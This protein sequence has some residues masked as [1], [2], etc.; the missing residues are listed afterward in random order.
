MDLNRWRTV[1]VPIDLYKVLKDMADQ[2]DR[3]VSK[4]V[5]F[6]L[7]RFLESEGLKLGCSWTVDPVSP[8]SGGESLP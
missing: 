5:T 6:I 2:N 7:K 4:Q 8:S 1:A 3:S